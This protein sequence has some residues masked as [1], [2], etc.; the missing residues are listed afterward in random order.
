M[1][2]RFALPLLL[3]VAL[4]AVPSTALA[5]P[6]V[7]VGGTLA[8]VMVSLEGENTTIV[9]VPSASFGLFNPGV[10]ASLFVGSYVSVEPQVGFLWVSSE[11]ESEHLLSAAAQFNYFFAG[12]T[13]PSPYA[14][15]SGGIL[16]GSGSSENPKSVTAGAGYRIPVGDRLTFR[17]DGR[18]IHFTDD[19]GN[20][21][22]FALSIGGVFG[23]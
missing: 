15:V 23:R 3:V 18:Y 9:G 10:Y 19:G 4:V 22:A 16:D 20:A 1:K 6:K 8:S 14:F 7:E 5:Q 11:G 21:V 2:T 12:T 13:R 17:V